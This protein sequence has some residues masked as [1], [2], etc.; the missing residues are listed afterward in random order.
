M[1]REQKK[2]GTM[3]KELKE[4]LCALLSALEL[5]AKKT[6]NPIDDIV[7]KGLQA[8]LGCK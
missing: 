2:G 7:I 8:M 3:S 1:K 6:A 5:L 4:I